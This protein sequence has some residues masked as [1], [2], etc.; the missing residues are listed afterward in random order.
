MCHNHIMQAFCPVHEKPTGRLFFKTVRIALC[1]N[2]GE[3]GSICM[4]DP[5]SLATV[6]PFYNELKHIDEARDTLPWG[7]CQDCQDSGAMDYFN[8]TKTVIGKPFT[9]NPEPSGSASD[10]S[11]NQSPE[12]EHAHAGHGQLPSIGAAVDRRIRASRSDPNLFAPIG[13]MGIVHDHLLEIGAQIGSIERAFGERFS[14]LREK[15]DACRHVLLKFSNRDKSDIVDPYPTVFFP[16]DDSKVSVGTGPQAGN[17]DRLESISK[18]TGVSY[19]AVRDSWKDKETCPAPNVPMG[20]GFV[21]LQNDTYINTGDRKDAKAAKKADKNKVR[22]D[23]AA[24]RD[25]WK[26]LF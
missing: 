9:K 18:F 24:A 6:G 25:K 19:D 11:T 3:R 12:S 1:P 8:E 7:V 17:G 15:V 5:Y 22:P 26:Y 16:P 13:E 2:P 10:A 21:S 20:P 14:Y 4:Q 23:D